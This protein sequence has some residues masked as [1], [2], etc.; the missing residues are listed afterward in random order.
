MYKK[1]RHT[2]DEHKALFHHHLLEAGMTR[3]A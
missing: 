1:L 2:F 3:K